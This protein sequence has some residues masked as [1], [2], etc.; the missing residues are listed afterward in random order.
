MTTCV[1][2]GRDVDSQFCPDCGQNTTVL[3]ITWKGVII[4]I[5][6][7]WLGMDNRF[8]RTFVNLS[9]RPTLVINEYLAGNR[10][11]Y[12]GPI[13]YLI[14]M[15]ALYILSFN[16]FGITPAEFMQN[17]AETFGGSELN[18]N[19]DVA[20]KQQEFMNTYLSVFSSNMRL[21][22][23]SIIPF[24]ALGLTMFYRRTRNYLENF[25]LVSYLSSHLLWVSILMIGLSSVFGFGFY[26]MTMLITICYYVWVI[27]SL[28]RTNNVF[29][30]YL[31]ALIS[32]IVSYIFF[33]LAMSILAVV[34]VI[35][36]LSQS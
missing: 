35:V 24:I 19:Q 11:K 8:A 15:T 16:V 5:S 25:L 21:M 30:T 12:I 22:V 7:R 1:N 14:V 32:W 23:A 18:Q 34:T 2:C 9:V 17:A 28:N 13:S 31:K 26:Y 6:S 29:W 33:V 10:V 3:P 36:L 27:G 4:S 20:L